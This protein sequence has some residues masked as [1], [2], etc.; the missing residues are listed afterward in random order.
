MADLYDWE[1]RG[2]FAGEARFAPF[3]VH[4]AEFDGVDGEYLVLG[5]AERGDPDGGINVL[6]ILPVSPN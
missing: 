3:R 6:G 1:S 4:F 2:D 5:A